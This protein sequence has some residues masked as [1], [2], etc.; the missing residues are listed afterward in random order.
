MVKQGRT[1][2]LDRVDS[3]TGYIPSNVQWVHKDINL[4]KN[5]FGQAYF[6]ELC[7]RVS[8]LGDG[9][10]PEDLDR[11]FYPKRGGAV[12]ILTQQHKDA[13]QRGNAKLS[14]EDVVIIRSELAAKSTSKAAL[15]ERFG[16]SSRN[17]RSIEL[18]ETWKNI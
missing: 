3:V 11:G 9:P 17:I 14:K 5:R 16:V 4:M 18:R 10:L 2:S 12:K 7:R 13:I 15:A 8:G 6:R 1:A